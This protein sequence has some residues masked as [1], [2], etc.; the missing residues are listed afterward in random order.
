MKIKYKAEYIIYITLL[1]EP[2]CLTYKSRKLK[3]HDHF[4]NK[5]STLKPKLR[6]TLM[7]ISIIDNKKAVCMSAKA[8]IYD[9]RARG[10]DR[11]VRPV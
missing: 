11:E 2:E 7:I 10:V 1:I 6:L 5:A 3:V 9:C 8:G 4:I